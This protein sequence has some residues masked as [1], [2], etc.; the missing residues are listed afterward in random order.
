MAYR[1]MRSTGGFGGI[2]PDP[3]IGCTKNCAVS[4]AGLFRNVGS[5]STW[6]AEQHYWNEDTWRMVLH[7]STCVRNYERLT[8]LVFGEYASAESLSNAAYDLGLESTQIDAAFASKLG[9]AIKNFNEIFPDTRWKEHLGG[10][11]LFE[12]PPRIRSYSVYIDDGPLDRN[13]RVVAYKRVL[14]SA[15]G[16]AEFDSFLSKSAVTIK[17]IPRYDGPCCVPTTKDTLYGEDVLFTWFNQPIGPVTWYWAVFGGKLVPSTWLFE[18]V[19]LFADKQQPATTNATRVVRA[20]QKSARMAATKMVARRVG[21]TKSGSSSSA[22][23]IGGS[24]VGIIAVSIVAV[25]GIATYWYYS[26]RKR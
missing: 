20:V 5:G 8:R 4:P 6:P 26:S 22:E 19:N 3:S 23:Q 24:S 21:D 10:A 2:S 16:Q 18:F 17:K 7:E 9:Q 11:I 12:T 15:A 14:G 25:A 13:L 1:M